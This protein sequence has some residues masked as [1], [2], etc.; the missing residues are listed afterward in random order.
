LERLLLQEGIADNF[1]FMVLEVIKQVENSQRIL[2]M[3]NPRLFDTM[4]SR[5]DYIDNLKSI[6][7]NKCFSAIHRLGGAERRAVDLLRALTTVSINLERIADYAVSVVAQTEYLAD[8]QFIKRYKYHAFFKHVLSALDMVFKAL[9]SQDVALAFK[10]CR[11]ESILDLLYKKQF[12]RILVHLRSGKDTG[13]LITSHLILRYLERMGDALLNIGEAI[14]FAALG[15]KF[16]IHQYEALK[17]TMTQSGMEVPISDIEF[18]SIWGTR[19]GCRISQVQQRKET[20]E[21][22]NRSEHGVL[23]KEGATRK[24]HQERENIE[25]WERIIPGLPPKILAFQEEGAQASLLTEFLGGCNYQDV[26]LTTKM[27]TLRN[28]TFLIEQLLTEIWDLTAEPGPV[29]SGFMK[30]LKN[31]LDDIYKLHPSFRDVPKHINSLRIHSLDELITEAE[32][33]D[34]SLTAPYSVFVHGDFNINNI[35]YDHVNQEIHFIDLHRSAQSDPLQDISVFIASNVR[36]P[37]FDRMLRARLNWVVRS[38]YNFARDAALQ[39]GD[40]TFDARLALGLARSFL[41]STRFEL[42]A[43]F[44]KELYLRGVY[45]LNRLLEHRGP[46]HEDFK[47]PQEILLY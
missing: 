18:H 14:I 33:L 5:D 46:T 21:G 11:V 8:K 40:T 44:A 36:L 30:Q 13:D 38:M 7:E 32:S 23:F 27:E 20:P 34:Q 15:E 9:I 17:E 43:K 35:I 3:P 39:K 29:S 24:L 42:N 1:R 16:K 2:D 6:I 37:V 22:P 31:R 25:R 10:I 4:E 26:L 19:S 12:D 45:L 28:A 41:T 47:L